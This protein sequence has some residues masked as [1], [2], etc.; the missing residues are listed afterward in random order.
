M[1]R[2]PFGRAMFSVRHGVEDELDA[3][4]DS[5]FVEDAEQVFLDGVLAEAEFGCDLAIAEAVGDEG[6]DL[7][8]AWG[9]KRAAAGVYDAQGGHFRERVHNVV[10]LLVVDPDL[11][12]KNRVDTF[13]QHAEG[14]HA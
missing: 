1:V 10:H 13:A 12:L 14:S 2:H 9:E 6:D 4:G 5:D 8:L 7:L 11:S 3:A